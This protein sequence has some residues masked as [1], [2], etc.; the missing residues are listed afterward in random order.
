[1]RIAELRRRAPLA[2]IFVLG[3][4]PGAWAQGQPDPG[5]GAPALEGDYETPPVLNAADLLPE[6][7]LTG[8]LFT[9]DPEVRNDGA[10]NHYVIRS[11]L[12]DAE[13]LGKDALI[14]AIQELRALD[15]LQDTPKRTGALVGFNYSM[16][17]LA[18][19]PYR[20]LKRVVFDPLYAIEAVPSEIA[21]YAGKLA[22]AGDLFEYG[23]RV[24]IRRSLGIDGARKLLARRL[25]VDDDTDNAALRDELRRVGW[26]VWM[27][28]LVP[29]VGDAYVDI[30]YDLSTEVGNIGD[31][32]LGRAVAALRKDVFPRT[33]RRML[34]KIDVPRG[35]IQEFRNHP[36][37]SGRMREGVAEA[38]RA[39][40]GVADRAAF[41]DWANTIDSAEY[42]RTAVR[43]AQVLALHHNGAEPLERL[44][45][46]DGVLVFEIE[47]G[48][49]VAPMIQDYL[50]WTREADIHFSMASEMG[51]DFA[52]DAPFAV[53]TMGDFSPRLKHE[54]AAR[55]VAFRVEVDE[56]YGRFVRQR[57][58][59]GRLEQR[60]EDRIANPIKQ[61]VRERLDTEGRQ[62]LT[63]PPL[64]P[65]SATTPPPGSPAGQV[66]RP[67][68]PSGSVRPVTARGDH[69][70]AHAAHPAGYP[71]AEKVRMRL[72][73]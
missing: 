44:Q 55:D 32:N 1:M 26:G 66:S 17:Q 22:A 20:K 48:P 37:F 68:A 35:M 54:L 45:H 27:G 62:R 42:A 51:R 11:P 15:L 33:A 41:V 58:G 61:Q 57:K 18:S 30:T 60:Y 36:H 72:N 56:D 19:A 25:N 52:P 28:G 2:L 50:I 8:E 39:M 53:W 3:L 4:A 13:A 5:T 49:V 64:G 65:Q 24:Y 43:L 69:A 6:Y 7:L 67:S 10:T 73:R 70:P 71:T 38:L 40:P 23:P 31:G 59:L 16:K 63:L 12:G 14:V 34:R 21:D 29:E 47:D 9:V 46:W